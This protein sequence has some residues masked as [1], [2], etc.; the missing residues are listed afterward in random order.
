ME[1]ADRRFFE[2]A[3]FTITLPPYQPATP[4]EIAR[5]RELGREATRLRELVGLI[6]ISSS[7]LIRQVRDEA[8]G[9]SEEEEPRG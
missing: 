2:D 9:L 4:E 8:E 1:R 7:D 3:N 5:R 6:G